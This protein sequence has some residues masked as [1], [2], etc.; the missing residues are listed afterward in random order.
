MARKNL[1]ERLWTRVTFDPAGCW[2]W[3]GGCTDRGYGTIYA[4]R[5]RYVHRVAYEIFVGPLVPGLTIDHL[6]RNR[7]CCNP[8][9]LEQVTQRE[10]ILRGNGICAR[11]ARGEIPKKATATESERWRRFVTCKRGHPWQTETTYT[12]P[13]TGKRTCRLCQRL[14]DKQRSQA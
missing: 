13:S 9:H 2:E 11:Y 14:R 3:Q 8:A 7:S 10:N 6:C 4:E 5:T 12:S 1:A